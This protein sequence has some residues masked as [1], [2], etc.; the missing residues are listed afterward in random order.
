MI[1]TPLR[2]NRSLVARPAIALCA[3]ALLLATSVF[4][5]LTWNRAA[6]NW[7]DAPPQARYLQVR[8]DLPEPYALGCD[9]W[10][11]S[12]KIKLCK[13]GGETAQMRVL[14]IGDSIGLQW[15]PAVSAAYLSRGWQV[16]VLTKSGCPMVD[17]SFFIV[18]TEA[19]M[20]TARSGAIKPCNWSAPCDL[21]K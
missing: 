14:I 18:G 13:F 12:G 11:H 15:F 19:T 4:G 1:E 21:T 2:R 20:S 5:G 6:K 8:S 10:F 17:Q 7:T 9:D 16:L 3:A